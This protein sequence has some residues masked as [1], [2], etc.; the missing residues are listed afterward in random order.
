MRERWGIGE[1]HYAA[2][3]ELAALASAGSRRR[4]RVPARQLPLFANPRRLGRLVRTLM[5]GLTG[6][7]VDRR[8][9]FENRAPSSSSVTGRT[10][11]AKKKRRDL[12]VA[13][14]TRSLFFF[15]VT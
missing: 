8:I 13:A 7:R 11:L 15:A 6:G 10:A 9:T 5:R 4:L 12:S 3:Q 14:L 1:L 2:A